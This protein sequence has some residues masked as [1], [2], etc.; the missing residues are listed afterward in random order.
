MAVH[1]EWSPELEAAL[2]EPFPAAYVKTKKLKGN[3]IAPSE[4]T[5]DPVTGCWN[6]NGCTNAKG[7]GMMGRRAAGEHHYYAH[8]WAYA[9]CVGS[10]P[11]GKIVCHRCDNPTCINP[12][13]LF[14]GT[15]SDNALDREQKG[16]G[17]DSSGENNPTASLTWAKVHAIRAAYR[18][19]KT[20]QVDLARRYGVDQTTISSIVRNKTWREDG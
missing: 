8:R 10:I 11:R 4:Y 18:R 14:L 17:R 12:A 15:H 19:G 3:E 16:R 6:W 9:V 7:Y 1:T 5:A 13:H 2:A 20:R